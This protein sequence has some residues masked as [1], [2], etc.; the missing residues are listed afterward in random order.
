MLDQFRHLIMYPQSTTIYVTVAF[1]CFLIAEVGIGVSLV[2]VG[3]LSPSSP[4]IIALGATSTLVASL[5]FCVYGM[6]LERQR[7]KQYAA[8]RQLGLYIEQQERALL[9]GE[10]P[11]EGDRFLQEKVHETEDMYQAVMSA[12]LLEPVDLARMPK[13]SVDLKPSASLS[14]G[15]EV[16][17]S[18]G[19]K[20]DDEK[21]G[22]LIGSL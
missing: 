16:I 6:G 7:L 5:L 1:Y 10:W 17:S 22:H 2:A 13:D 18:K 11:G 15:L 21:Q 3:A 12:S 14:E 4:A 8:G 20:L 19:R 9:L